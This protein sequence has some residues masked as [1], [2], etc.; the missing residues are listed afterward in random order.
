[1]HSWLAQLA[2]RITAEVVFAGTALSSLPR[3]EYRL[4]LMRL[5]GCL[6]VVPASGGVQAG[7]ITLQVLLLQAADV[8]SLWQNK[9][10]GSG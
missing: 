3:T 2:W 4:R 9:G 10:C 5:Q 7:T 1:M 6:E 8:W